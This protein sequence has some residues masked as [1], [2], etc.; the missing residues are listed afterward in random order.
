MPAIVRWVCTF[1]V[2]RCGSAVQPGWSD[3]KLRLSWS[4]SRLVAGVAQSAERLTRKDP[5][6]NAVAH[7]LLRRFRIHAKAYW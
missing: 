7:S 4:S 2:I 5:G 6:I 3:E 1:Q